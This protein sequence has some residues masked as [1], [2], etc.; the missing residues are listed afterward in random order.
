MQQTDGSFGHGYLTVINKGRRGFLWCCFWYTKIENMVD[1]V[2][3][4]L[5]H[6]LSLLS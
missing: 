5:N 4:D 1:M 6:R 3:T 2:D